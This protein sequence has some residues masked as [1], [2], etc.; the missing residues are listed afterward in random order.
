M[1]IN[2]SEKVIDKTIIIVLLALLATGL[3]AF[4]I[5]K[6]EDADIAAEHIKP[7]GNLSGNIGNNRD[8]AEPPITFIQAGIPT[9]SE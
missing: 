5:S 6:V 9:P 2:N 3:S 7:S 4:I 1:F 8:V